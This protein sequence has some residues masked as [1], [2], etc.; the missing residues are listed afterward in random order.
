MTTTPNHD[1]RLIEAARRRWMK[2]SE[3][4][5]EALVDQIKKMPPVAV[6]ESAYVK[7]QR[8]LKGSIK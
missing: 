7:M 8:R 2:L 1:P 5:R 3:P 6:Y 4:E